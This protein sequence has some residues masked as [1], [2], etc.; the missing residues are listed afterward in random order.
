VAK[1]NAADEAFRRFLRRTWRD[2]VAPLLKGHQASR[3]KKTARVGGRVAGA[4]GLAVDS[5]FHLKGRPFSRFMTTMGVSVGAMLPDVWD[6]KWFRAAGKAVRRLTEKR[7]KQAVAALPEADALELFGLTAS[8]TEDDL[9]IA[10]REISKRWH[11]DKASGDESRSEYH[12]RFVAYQSAHERLRAA[13][14]SQRLPRRA[15]ES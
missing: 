15:S 5:L 4:T 14:E 10:W 3:R 2:D 6:W 11:P 1:A 8:A 9:K 12:L 13:Y 7:V